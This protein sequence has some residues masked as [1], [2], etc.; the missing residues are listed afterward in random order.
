MGKIWR[1]AANNHYTIAFFVTL[2]VSIG[3]IIYGVVTP[4]K[5]EVSG[6]LL[7]SVGIIFLWPSLAFL[8]KAV[9][10]GKTAKIHKGDM[11]ISVGDDKDEIIDNTEE[12]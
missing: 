11:T 9:E 5:G 12:A 6:S 4:P 8:N 1:T 2:A 10:S 7:T 3:L